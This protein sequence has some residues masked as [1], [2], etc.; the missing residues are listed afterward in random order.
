MSSREGQ[1]DTNDLSSCA[2]CSLQGL[3]VEDFAVPILDSDTAGQNYFNDA[4]V[5]RDHD[6][7][8][9]TLAF[10]NLCRQWSRC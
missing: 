10:L 5:E 3:A 9:G 1:R 4:F 8:G 6:G 2:N 7:L